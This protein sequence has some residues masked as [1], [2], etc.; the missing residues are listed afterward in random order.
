MTRINVGQSIPRAFL[1]RGLM[2]LAC[3]AI[4]SVIGLA[5]SPCAAAETDWGKVAA[6]V[7]KSGREMPGGVYRVGLPRTDLHVA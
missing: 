2:H 3:A 5:A 7:G 4:A 1:R 6:A